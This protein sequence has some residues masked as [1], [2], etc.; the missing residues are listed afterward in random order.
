MSTSTDTLTPAA[1]RPTAAR[2][3]HVTFPRLVRSE[4][5]KFWTVRSTW[6]ILPITVLM[7]A[8]LGWLV[9]WGSM[10]ARPGR[11]GGSGGM[12]IFDATTLAG[13]MIA[14]AQLTIAVLAVLTITGEYTTWMIRTTLTAD[15]RR[16]G[17]LWAKTLVIVSVTFVVTTIG[18]A[19]TWLIAR[20]VLGNAN[21]LDL[22]NAETR[23]ILLGAPL[24]L[25]GI[26]LLAFA[27]G[28]LLRHS[29]AALATVFGLLLVIEVVWVNLPWTFFHKTSPFLPGSAGGKIFST[30]AAI[31]ASRAAAT[32]PV[33]T[34]W[35]GYGVL[36]AWG[37]VMLAVASVLLSRRDA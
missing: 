26:A 6:W 24:Y 22:S 9:T 32:G 5:I 17:A 20:Q 27:L 25:T 15:P 8:G 28:A 11:G 33:L 36:I 37:V 2:V 31:E 21:T 1:A 29:A 14:L 7:M 16:L 10:Q 13:V 30:D 35:V 34:P 3:P 19:L 23:M 18:A 4:W 12:E